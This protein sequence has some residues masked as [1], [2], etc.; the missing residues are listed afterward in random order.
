MEKDSE[1]SRSVRGGIER[2]RTGLDQPATSRCRCIH[3][4]LINIKVCE[5]CLASDGRHTFSATLTVIINR[6]GEHAQ[7]RLNKASVLFIYSDSFGLH[8][9]ACRQDQ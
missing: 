6:L 4:M 9:F 8:S 2:R 5:D 7:K 1:S 3:L